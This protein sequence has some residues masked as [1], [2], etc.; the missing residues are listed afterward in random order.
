MDR[1]TVELPEHLVELL[2]SAVEQGSYASQSEA[3]ADALQ[4]WDDRRYYTPEAVARLRVIVDEG[5][6][7]GPPEPLDMAQIKQKAREGFR[8]A[9]P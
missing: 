1:V 4:A 3:V 7:S 5:L 6:A 9:A 8:R 2:R